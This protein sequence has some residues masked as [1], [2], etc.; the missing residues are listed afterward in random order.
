MVSP[1]EPLDAV[2]AVAFLTLLLVFIEVPFQSKTRPTACLHWS[3]F[4]YFLI[5]TIGY[6]A[7]TFLAANVA[8]PN[9]PGHP[10]FWHVFFGVFGFHILL[11]QT[12][13]TIFDKG[14]LTIQDWI[15]KALDKAVSE[16]LKT[17]LSQD[18]QATISAARRLKELPEKELN[19]YVEQYLGAGKVATLEDGAASS[20]TDPGHYKAFALARHKPEGA[21]A[22]LKIHTDL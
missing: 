5:S 12:N 11:R 4:L 17:E 13:I 20:G 15:Q 16:S 9:L 1:Y 22:I 7:G 19:L 2:L 10:L 6:C 14:V 18:L 21:E 3:T 8:S